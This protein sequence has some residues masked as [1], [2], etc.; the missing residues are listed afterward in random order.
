MS[1]FHIPD[2]LAPFPHPIP[3]VPYQAV[4]SAEKYPTL[5][6]NRKPLVRHNELPAVAKNKFSSKTKPTFGAFLPHNY[7]PPVGHK[8]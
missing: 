6:M 7:V 3:T 8:H 5:T 1:S 2:L 4:H